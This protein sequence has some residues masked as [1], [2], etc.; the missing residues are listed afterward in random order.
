VIFG[1]LPTRPATSPNGGYYITTRMVGHLGGS[2]KAVSSVG[3]GTIGPL[4]FGGNGTLSTTRPKGAVIAFTGYWRF[5]EI[6]LELL[7]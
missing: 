2:K 1:R 3:N 6:G 7:D 5:R 4:D